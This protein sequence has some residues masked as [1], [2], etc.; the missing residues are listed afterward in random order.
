[1]ITNEQSAEI[2]MM[3][4]EASHLQNNLALIQ[5]N[6]EMTDSLAELKASLQGIFDALTEEE[7]D[8]LLEQYKTEADLLGLSKL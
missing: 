7:R 6:P 2:T 3:M 8:G 4:R 1:M 5:D